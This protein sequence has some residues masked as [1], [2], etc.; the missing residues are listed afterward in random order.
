MRKFC[1]N[2][3][4]SNMK[5][6]IILLN[7]LLLCIISVTAQGPFERTYPT[8][9]DRAMRDVLKTSDGGY[10]LC[11]WTNT[12]DPTECDVFVMRTDIN[13]NELPGWPKTYGKSGTA[14]VDFAYSMVETTDGNYFIAGYSSSYGGGDIDVYLLKI[15]PDGTEIFTKTF[16]GYSFDEAREIIKT[17]DNNYVIVGTTTNNG[18]Q[19]AFL[20]KVDN[21][22]N[23]VWS[24]AMKMFG[25]NNREFGNAVAEAPDGSLI[26]TGQSMNTDARGDTYLV[27]TTDT[28]VMVWE[29]WHGEPLGD[30]GTGIVVNADGSSVVCI[31]DSTSASDIDVRVRKFDAQGNAVAGFNRLFGGASKDTPKCLTTAKDGNYYL[32]AISRSWNWRG[33]SAPDSPD[34]WLLKINAATGD[35]MWTRNFGQADHD[36]LEQVRPDPVQDAILLC[37]HSVGQPYA[38]RPYFLKINHQGR[39]D[40]LSVENLANGQVLKVG[41][42]PFTSDIFLSGLPGTELTVTLS[43]LAGRTIKRMSLPVGETELALP[44]QELLTGLYLLRI[45]SDKEVRTIRLVRE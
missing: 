36:H 6:K 42:N 4:F 11:G 10:I 31:R 22:G 14:K 40:A 5:N 3:N 16:G 25:G 8:I 41:P 28:G 37:G 17:A 29:Q 34:M 26:L 13:G 7:I 15:A 35:T 30:E 23:P 2:I 12:T 24:P 39:V 1:F 21:A 18:N 43:D 9:R 44:T 19:Q 38:K 27:K 33:N 32:G 45:E 20:L